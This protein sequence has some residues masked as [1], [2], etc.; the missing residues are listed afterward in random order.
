[1]DQDN[2]DYNDAFYV[3]RL[4]LLAGIDEM[5]GNVVSRLDAAGL[6]DSTYIVYTTDNGFHIGQHRLQPGKSCP[7]EEDY[8]VPLII[9]GP[10]MPAGEVST[11]GFFFAFRALTGL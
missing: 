6:L 10:G 2:I 11:L 8:I 5:V 4:Q 1:L 7:I 3:A 9:R